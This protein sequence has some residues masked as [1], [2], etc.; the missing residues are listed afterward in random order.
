[1]LLMYSLLFCCLNTANRTGLF[2][3][4]D[5]ALDGQDRRTLQFIRRRVR[6]HRGWQARLGIEIPEGFDLL[7]F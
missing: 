3:L 6:D 7:H 5:L 1:M 4:M 2:W